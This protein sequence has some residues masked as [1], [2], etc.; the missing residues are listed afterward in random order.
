M[1]K[2]IYRVVVDN[3]IVYEGHSVLD[4]R[5]VIA[6]NA[7]RGEYFYSLSR[8]MEKDIPYNGNNLGQM[9]YLGGESNSYCDGFQVL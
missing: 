2:L 8:Y 3:V 4:A 1:K 6:S 7:E 5:A 9:W